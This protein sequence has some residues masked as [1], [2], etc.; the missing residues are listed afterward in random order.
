MVSASQSPNRLRAATASGRSSIDTRF[1]MGI[2]SPT[3]LLRCLSRCSS[4]LYKS[5]PAALS[6]RMYWYIRSWLTIGRPSRR[7]SPTICSGEY[8]S[9]RS[10][11]STSF[12]TASVNF[13]ALPYRSLRSSAIFCALAAE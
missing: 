6:A 1:L 10:H 3:G 13:R 7:A 4:C 5:P 8:C 12:R 11:L 9:C 2:L